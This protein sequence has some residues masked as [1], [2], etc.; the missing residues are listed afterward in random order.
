MVERAIGAPIQSPSICRACTGWFIT[1]IGVLVGWVFFRATSI[2]QAFDIVVVMFTGTWSW[3]EAMN[4]V[5]PAASLALI[6]S[7][8][9]SIHWALQS[10]GLI[11]RV[12]EAGMIRQCS[13]VIAGILMAVFLRGQG[14]E[15]IYFQF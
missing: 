7:L 9:A 10:R 13:F 4:A 8:L 1:M 14:D 2:G 6:V 11:S 12:G 15:F 5:N 3:G